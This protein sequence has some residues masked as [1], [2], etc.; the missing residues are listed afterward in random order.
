MPT[1]ILLMIDGIKGESSDSKHPDAIEVLSYDWGATNKGSMASGSGG[2]AGKVQFKDLTF[3]A[4]ASQASPALMRA[5][6]TGEH[7]EEATFYARKQGGQQEVYMTLTLTGV[8]VAA[9]DSSYQLDGDGIV[10]LDQVAFNYAQ[11]HLNYRPQKKDGTLGPAFT[12]GY[13][14]KQNKKI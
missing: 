2:G 7:I 13:N 14:L 5:C 6:A 10:L 12:A 11:I 4:L 8:L 1:D 9:Y 3:T